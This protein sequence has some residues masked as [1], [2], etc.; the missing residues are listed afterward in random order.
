MKKCYIVMENGR[1]FEGVRFGA[2]ATALGEMVF[3]TS[4]CGYLETLTD[5]CYKGQIVMQTFPLNGNYGII[6]EDLK[7][8]V[9]AAA[10]VVRSWCETPS[11]FRSQYDMDTFL[12]RRGIAGVYGVDTREITR[13]LRMNGVM[14]AAIVDEIPEDL[15]F[16]RNYRVE[17]AV[18]AVSSGKI[19]EYPA[20]GEEKYSVAVLDFGDKA[21]IVDEITKRGCRVCVL[22]YDT[23]AETILEG[24]YQGVVISNGPGDP[25]D[26]AAAVAEIK[27]LLGKVAI[28]GIGL[29]HQMLALAAGG[30][31]IKLKFGHRGGNQPVRFLNMGRT[32]ITS[33]NHGYA[34]D[35]DKLPV[36]VRMIF[37]NANDGTCEGLCY[38]GM[39]AF[40]AQFVPEISAG[41]QDNSFLYDRFVQQMGGNE[42]CL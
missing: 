2:D 36:G 3:T 11:N 12:K 13:L 7:R 28:F 15:S 24:G 40:S 33:Q 34:V 32:Y 10:Y 29:G 17:N 37:E 19:E 38:D 18:A 1:V 20:K 35:A 16:I 14:N 41:P 30:E 39:K 5:P 22:P 21:N 6:E 8:D 9:H 23:A 26:N 4:V 27:K 25:R 42:I 31:V